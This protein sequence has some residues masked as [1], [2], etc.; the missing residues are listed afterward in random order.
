MSK[1]K[2]YRVTMSA[3]GPYYYADIEASSAEEAI[4][5]ALSPTTDWEFELGD[6][7]GD[8]STIEVEYFAE[9]AE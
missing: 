4:D 6:A 9:G 3:V 1:T 8:E 2:R 5:L 7:E